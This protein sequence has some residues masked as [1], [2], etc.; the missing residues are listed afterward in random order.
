MSRRGGLRKSESNDSGGSPG[1]LTTFSDL[2]SLLLTF[3]ILLYSMSTID[4]QKFKNITN[5]LQAILSG[6]GQPMIIEGGYE[7][8]DSIQ[9]DDII[10]QDEKIRSE[11]TSEK[12]QAMYDKVANYVLDQG[13]DAKVTVT[14]NRRGVFVDIKETI[15][16]EPGKAEL[17][18]S[19][20]QILK[21]LKGLVID[22]DNEMV[23]EG[24][25][26][27]VPM[28][29]A[30]YPSNWELS[31]ARGVSVVRY[32]SE[33]EGIDPLRLSAIGYGE[34]RPIVPNNSVK[35]RASNR[36]VNIL[37]IINEESEDVNSN[38]GSS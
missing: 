25:T 27:D 15:L 19:G 11:I 6:V 14:S 9:I 21:Q 17:K 4:V 2:M 29:S 35:N 24:H 12:I 34:Y 13:L 23:I 16:F 1:W 38:G 36:R 20:V 3:F 10:K 37:I 8:N 32:L 31:T 22:F 26:D 7:G 28:N 18:T 33:V 5:S 30:I